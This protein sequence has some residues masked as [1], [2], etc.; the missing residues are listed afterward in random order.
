MKDLR[1]SLKLTFAAL[2]A[3]LL[4][5]G[6]LY[7]V[8]DGNEWFARS[9]GAVVLVAGIGALCRATLLIPAL[10]VPLIQAAAVLVYVSPTYASD[11]ANSGWLPGRAALDTLRDR[12]DA[13]FT[14]IDTVTPPLT[15]SEQVTL[16]VVVGVALMAILVDLLAA[17]LR[18]TALAGLPLLVLYVVPAAVLPNGMDGALFLLPAG[19][20]LLLLIT[21]SRE[22]LLRWGVAVSGRGGEARTTRSAGEL[23]QMTR[24]IGVTVLSMSIVIPALAPRLS[25]GAF[26]AGG[27]GNDPDGGGTISTL[28]PLVSMR[29]DLVRPQDLDLMTVRTNSLDAG[30][31]YLRA[32]TL[33]TFDG[34]EWR[35]GRREVRR[36]DANLPDPKAG[37][38]DTVPNVPVETS[39]QVL[40]NLQSDY[41]PM[42]FP[43]TRLE[44]EGGWRVDP[45][46]NNVVSHNGPEQITGMTYSVDSVDLDPRPTDVTA[47]L[48]IDPYLAP[49]LELPEDLPQRVKDLAERVTKGTDTILARAI[50]LQQWF[51]D[52]DE[53]AYDLRQRPGTGKD[54]ILAFL[55]DRRGYC[56]QFASTM[57]VMARHLK[58]P[59][60]V[61]VGF[62]PGSP[63][64][65]GT[66]T[67][68]AHDAHA[69]PELWMPGVGWTR[70][71]PTPGSA[72]SNPDVPNWLSPKPPDGQTGGNEGENETE[73]T[74]SPE[75]PTGATAPPD[76]A[77][78]NPGLEGVLPLPAED[79]C[80]P[81]KYVDA[82]TDECRDPLDPWYQRWWKAG[83]TGGLLLL[84][85]LVP[86]LAR[87][88]VR[89]R[90]WALVGTPGAAGATG[91]AAEWTWVEL[92]DSAIDLGY[93]WPEARTPRQTSAEL[94][95]DGKL[96]PNSSDALAM[97]TQF[98]ERVRYAPGD[99]VSPGRD[100]LRGA[101]DEVRRDL[102][103]TA[104]RKRRI[105]ALLW[106]RSLGTLL[107]RVAMQTRTKSVAA[108]QS[109]LRTLRLRRA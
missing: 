56:E 44:I 33:D 78:V 55:E 66:R 100:Q 13:G 15:P 48:S 68:S 37:L 18:Q 50:A 9:A 8:F 31:L 38:S 67:V 71:E 2:V 82:K 28:N 108:R 19:G 79:T 24:R 85:L 86:P 41:V 106:P 109:V 58:I 42:P 51:R 17:G 74:P 6:L 69:W 14:E 49:Y 72:A 102:G 4:T 53:F 3:C 101:V 73:A 84:L 7:S 76:P 12:L 88:A 16:V 1:T 94:A 57:A 97:I 90:R 59:A 35:A 64:P 75:P 47:A 83:A 39:V 46:T 65:D 52:P 26:G 87:V 34:E 81:P 93:I 92:R 22:R 10:L 27:I 32:V 25:D 107:G 54:A 40:G 70:F 36:F 11:D 60:R 96:G 21:D 62:T 5:T 63:N 89:R 91:P 61:N 20:Y 98:V 29:R 104:G 99:A 45:L 23:G 103:N 105:Q 95:G 30:E 77:T 80:L 43:A